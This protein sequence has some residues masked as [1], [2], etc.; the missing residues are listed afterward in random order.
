MSAT[1][2]SSHSLDSVHTLRRRPIALV[3]NCKEH[4]RD[5]AFKVEPRRLRLGTRFILVLEQFVTATTTLLFATTNASAGI[6]WQFRPSAH[7]GCGEATSVVE[8]SVLAVV[9]HDKTLDILVLIE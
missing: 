5:Y 1:L 7:N 8:T 4:A 3:G 9:L 6:L 2:D